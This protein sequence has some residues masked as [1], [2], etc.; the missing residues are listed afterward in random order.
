MKKKEEMLKIL[1][2]ILAD[3]KFY[4]PCDKLVSNADPKVDRWCEK[5]CRK[6][7]AGTGPDAKCWMKY[8]EVIVNERFD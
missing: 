7:K 2:E 5:H 4:T 6:K 1:A 3:T 8:A